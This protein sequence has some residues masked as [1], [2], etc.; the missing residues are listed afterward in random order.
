[1]ERFA[2]RVVVVTGAAS[3]IGRR[4]AERFAEEGAFVVLGDRNITLAREA[5]S[6]IG[7][8]ARAVEFDAMDKDSVTRLID[9]AADVFG[10]IDVLHNN[11]AMTTEAWGADTTVLDTSVDV[12]DRTMSINLRSTFIAAKA[13]LKYMIPKKSGSIINTSSLSAKNGG[14]ALVAYGTSKAAVAAFTKYL[15]V[16]YGPSGIRSNCVAPG[17]TLTEQILDNAPGIAERAAATNSKLGTPD[18]IASLVLFLASDAATHI[19]GQV[20]GC[21]G[22]TSAGLTLQVS[23]SVPTQNR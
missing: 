1:M 15:A 21:D 14:P 6:Q 5:A 2:K 19:N 8:V 20:I 10:T 12:W 18:D 3:G 13:A 23:A 16:Q 9:T 4:T 11:V 22:G 17:I 7:S